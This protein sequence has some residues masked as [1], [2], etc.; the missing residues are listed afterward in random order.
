[1]ADPDRV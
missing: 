1:M